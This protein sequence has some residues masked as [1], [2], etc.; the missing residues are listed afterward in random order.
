MIIGAKALNITFADGFTVIRFGR[1]FTS[2]LPITLKEITKPNKLSKQNEG[3]FPIC[4]RSMHDNILSWR[5]SKVV[6]RQ[7]KRWF[8]IS[9]FQKWTKEEII[10]VHEVA[11]PTNTKKTSKLALQYIR[12]Q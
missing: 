9:F 4:K 1:S 3:V 7:I 11:V 12:N 2:L 8:S 5:A 10:T 6:K